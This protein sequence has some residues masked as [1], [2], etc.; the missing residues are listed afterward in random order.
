MNDLLDLK[1]VIRFLA[2]K[3]VRGM[4]ESEKSKGGC[5]HTIG[6]QA[7]VYKP[8]GRIRLRTP[9]R[10]RRDESRWK[11]LFDSISRLGQGIYGSLERQGLLSF[12]VNGDIVIAPSAMGTMKSAHLR[13]FQKVLVFRNELNRMVDD[14]DFSFRSLA[15]SPMRKSEKEDRIIAKFTDLHE[16]ALLACLAKYLTAHFDRHLSDAACAFR[17]GGKG[18]FNSA[19]A[20]IRDF[21]MRHNS[22]PLYVAECDLKK[23]YDTVNHDVLKEAFMQFSALARNAGEPIDHRAGKILDAYL[24]SYSF[25]RSVLEATDDRMQ[26]AIK[27]NRIPWVS[28]EELRLAYSSQGVPFD[29]IGIPQ[30]GAI[31]PL[32]ANIMLHSV[33]NSVLQEGGRDISQDKDFFYTRFCDDMVIISSDM[34]KCDAA[35]R[36]YCHEAARLKLLMHNPQTNYVK[37]DANWWNGKTR[38]TYEWSRDAIPWIGFVG[39]QIRY[40]GE[41]RLRRQTFDRINKRLSSE[42][43]GALCEIS[44]IANEQTA[45]YGTRWEEILDVKNR[46]I[47]HVTKRLTGKPHLRF[48]NRTRVRQYCWADAFSLLASVFDGSAS[49]RRQIGEF[50]RMRNNWLNWFCRKVDALLPEKLRQPHIYFGKPFSIFDAISSCCN[51]LRNRPKGADASAYASAI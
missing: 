2:K 3:C 26:K 12:A 41:L 19:A 11:N 10:E 28:D 51:S 29:K 24:E 7:L 37:Y 46:T 50:D 45:G 25:R 23:F 33:D 13:W 40:D 20:Q 14:P 16:A 27:G 48:R 39:Y 9:R 36:R 42:I 32:L 43:S 44:K 6:Q 21:R 38:S 47:A 4:Q 34:N 5:H 22:V 8:G 15:V 35:F 30:G 18:G 49:S 17:A 31:S 1:V